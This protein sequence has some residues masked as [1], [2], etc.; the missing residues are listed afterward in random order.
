[1]VRRVGE[2]A[3]LVG[4]GAL[5]DIELGGVPPSGRGAVPNAGF[6]IAPDG[7]AARGAPPRLDQDREEILA[8]LAEPVR[9]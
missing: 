3:A 2:A 6:R 1:M 9:K 5:Q 8:W 7:P 4:E